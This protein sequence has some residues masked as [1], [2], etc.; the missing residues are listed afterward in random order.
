MNRLM[1]AACLS[2]LLLAAGPAA[3][4]QVESHALPRQW[5]VQLLPTAV[6]DL[7]MVATSELAVPP[8]FEAPGDKSGAEPP[9]R[10]PGGEAKA[11]SLAD[12]LPEPKKVIELAQAG[13]WAEAIQA[14]RPLMEKSK[15]AYG[16]FTWDYLAN[17]MAWALHQSDLHGDAANL[18]RQA[19]N[20]IT[21]EDLKKYH[22]QAARVISEVIDGKAAPRKDGSRILSENLKDPATLR[23]LLQA[24]VAE[25]LVQFKKHLEIIPK[26][27]TPNARIN[28]IRLAY[29]RLRLMKAVDPALPDEAPAA[30]R[31][32][33]D[34]LVTDAAAKAL[35]NTAAQY[36]KVGQVLNTE[37]RKSDL[38]RLWNPEVLSLWNMISEVKRLCRIHDYLR[39]MNLA[40]SA[41]ASETFKSAHQ[42]LYASGRPGEVYRP[43]GGRTSYY[44]RGNVHLTA[45]DNRRIAP[46]DEVFGASP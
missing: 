11:V 26:A 35:E 10:I 19:A 25:E 4:A 45:V 17:A 39:R 36:R 30:L 7:P 21:D 3:L 23:A 14:G 28:N 44:D 34:T 1:F 46:F 37:T 31:A 41:N 16:D 18:H 40:G 42:M 20:Q 2:T 6:A 9:P 12:M 27:N 29:D 24:V 8:A 33:V 13:K 15:E 5:P 32:A 43:M 38:Q 22:R